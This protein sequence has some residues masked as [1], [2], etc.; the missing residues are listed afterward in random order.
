VTALFSAVLWSAALVAVATGAISVGSRVWRGGDAAFRH[1][2]WTT[3]AVVSLLMPVI[4]MVMTPRVHLVLPQAAPLLA[5]ATGTLGRMFEVVGVVYLGGVAVALLRIVAGLLVVRRLVGRSATPEGLPADRLQ[6]A[7]GSGADKCRVHQRLQVPITVGW[8]N[9]VVLLPPT[10]ILWD[11]ARRDAVVRHELA[12]V[13]RRDF[14][15]N[16]VAAVQHAI[17]WFSPAAWVVAHRI[18]LLAELACDERAAAVVGT[19]TYAQVLVE[20]AR[21]ATRNGTRAGILAVGATTEL[22]ARVEAL[23]SS[24][25]RH[26]LPSSRW[27]VIWLAAVAVLLTASATIRVTANPA[28]VVGVF[29][30]EHVATHQAQHQAAHQTQHQH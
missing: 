25:P 13:G 29:S 5:S 8:L 16:L 15:W 22:E 30:P 7:I 10:W 6:E 11:T 24:A 28:A 23:I 2:L 21:D 20:T 18:R 9:P 17:Y 12:H 27:R 3:V 4:A 1:Q 26:L 14:V 19:S